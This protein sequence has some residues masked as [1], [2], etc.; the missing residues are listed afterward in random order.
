MALSY[1]NNY[2]LVALTLSI[3]I[4]CKAKS[5]LFSKTDMKPTQGYVILNRT[6]V[7]SWFS[8][9][10][11]NPFVDGTQ[12]QGNRAVV[13]EG[14][15]A[16]NH[17]LLYLYGSDSGILYLDKNSLNDHIAQDSFPVELPDSKK[18]MLYWGRSWIQNPQKELTSRAAELCDRLGVSIIG[19]QD[20]W[21]DRNMVESLAVAAQK[22]SVKQKLHPKDEMTVVMVVGEL[23]RREI[24]GKW[25]LR[26]LYSGYNPVY[27]PYILDESGYIY[28]VYYRVSKFLE[29][30]NRLFSTFFKY[31]SPELNSKFED[32]GKVQNLFILE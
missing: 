3:L 4:G 7:E 21:G 5:T 17:T 26:K 28:P 22:L 30:E 2:L 25:V 12:L 10:L 15:G 16:E 32:A 27:E 9:N 8:S 6:E 19:D 11:I 20:D 31:L 13:Y 14:R 18:D 23:L 1:T 29:N 24:Q